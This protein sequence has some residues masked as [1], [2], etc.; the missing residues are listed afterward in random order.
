MI[1]SLAKDIA[2]CY[3]IKAVSEGTMM[4]YSQEVKATDFDSV[5]DGS[6]PSIPANL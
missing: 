3:N 6:N 2:I 5:T 4:G 1:K